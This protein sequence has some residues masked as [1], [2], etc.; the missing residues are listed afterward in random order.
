MTRFPRP[1]PVIAALLAALASAP[2][3]AQELAV[4]AVDDSP[5]AQLALEQAMDQA[6]ANPREAVRLLAAALDAGPLR[7]VRA[8]ADPDLFVTVSRR[9]HG[10]L[11]ADAA[12]RTAF[13]REL[14]P[15]ADERLAR[16][17]LEFL[18]ERRLDTRAGVRACI[19][20]AERALVRGRFSAARGLLDRIAAHD[21]VD[22]DL[23]AHVARLAGECARGPASPAGP[24][25]QSFDP[26]FASA[27]WGET[28]RIAFD[29]GAVPAVADERARPGDAPLPRSMPVT[30]GDRVFVSDGGAIRAFDRLGGR[31][32]WSVPLDGN[33]G[34]G[35]LRML[36]AGPGGVVGFAV[37]AGPARTAQPRVVCI[38]PATGAVRVDAR[39]DRAG[40]PADLDGIV[41]EGT[42]LEVDGRI[43]TAARRTSPR[44]ETVSW[45]LS[46]D[47]S[48]SA[49]VPW[50]RALATTGSV[51]VGTS[52]ISE[53]P[54]LAGGVLYV[55]TATGAVA[56]VDPWDGFIRWLRRFPVPVRDAGVRSDSL[57]VIM[58]AVAG[59][60]VIALTPD[61]ARLV[62]LSAVDGTAISEVPTAADA[63]QSLP[64]SLVGD[65]ASGLVALV[66]ERLACVRAEDPGVALWTLPEVER[67]R[68]RIRF[69]STGDPAS[70]VLVVPLAQDLLFIDARTG[71]E[72]L[73]LAGAGGANV[74]CAGNQLVAAGTSTL[75]GW[76]PVSE[77][78][79]IVRARMAGSTA[80]GDALALAALARQVRSGPM[81]AEAAREAV[82]RSRGESDEVRAEVLEALLSLDALE[83]AEGADRSALDAAVDAAAVAAGEEVRGGFVRAQ[84]AL[85]RGD[86]RA[87]VQIAVQ[88]TVSAPEGTLV[89]HVDGLASPEA[90]CRRITRDARAADAGAAA[91]LDSA[92]SAAVA[93]APAP[94]RERMVRMAARIGA[95]TA[96]GDR[97]LAALVAASTEPDAR[98]AAARLA[99]E[100]AVLGAR[101][102][103]S[104]ARALALPVSAL[105]PPAAPAVLSGEPMRAIECSGRLPRMGAGAAPIGGGFLSLDGDRLV[106]RT[107]PAYSPRW[108]APAG[109]PDVTV[110]STSPDIIVC[111]DALG[112]SGRL[113]CIS[114]DGVLRWSAEPERS[115]EAAPVVDD[116]PL[117]EEPGLE[118]VRRLRG[119]GAAGF[120]GTVT[121]AV[122]SGDGAV[123]AFGR[124]RGDRRWHR[125]PVGLIAAWAHEAFAIALAEEVDAEIRITV[126]DPDDGRQILSWTCALA[127][128]VRWMRFAAGGLLVVG[129]D[130]G[131]EARRIAGGDEGSP[132]WTLDSVDARESARGWTPL[133]MVAVLDR[134]D[135]LR[136]ADAWSGRFRG[137]DLASAARSPVRD[138]VAGAGW[139]AGIRDDGVDFLDGTG[140]PIGR[141][142][143][144]AERSLVAAA[145]SAD[146][147]FVLD[148]GVEGSDP[149]PMRFGALL[150]SLAAGD[151]GREPEPPLLV[152]MLGQRPGSLRVIDGG[153]AVS[154]GTSIQVFEFSRPS[155][156]P[157]R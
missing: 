30:D 77:A 68:G 36:G 67:V 156:V 27:R 81:A 112:G 57:D 107:A 45:L 85:R 91:V 61:R 51:R 63:G 121:V 78:E 39:L 46:V 48:G 126:I 118:P 6:R 115:T 83:L 123:T 92:V 137:A 34:L 15:D 26:S 79:R 40:A 64:T 127:S 42:P 59:D 140:R 75:S 11:A 16:G 102:D 5:S 122:L 138:V 14:D 60:R 7:L 157:G 10:V 89:P 130:D 151:G 88:T 95:G 50:A 76:M 152:R 100:C 111:D 80:A 90:E 144:G 132:Y 32:L 1:I 106:M 133:G 98:R 142:A 17:E 4:A 129:T 29:G 84:R 54:V 74:A 150:H 135:G 24:V 141:D 155:A 147:L 143:P 73:R 96:A 93:S 131:I 154:N 117:G 21:L 41:P 9:V 120:V 33:E 139:I 44:L 153:V 105:Q 37:N 8:G 149:V 136:A 101:A 124:E 13:R 52:R 53:S 18:V 38:D 119:V 23:A 55:A 65:P 12:L 49:S 108:Q 87:A 145:A 58:P 103:E 104:V 25:P 97:A 146:R 28:W 128:E 71:A 31:A 148:A 99:R 20:L 3:S 82:R 109:G 2:S 35:S 22:G 62:T 94:A 66:G 110:L 69:A 134:F 125:P 113:T 47:A 43:I 72:R 70:P 114:P 116:P 56:A 19:A 86:V